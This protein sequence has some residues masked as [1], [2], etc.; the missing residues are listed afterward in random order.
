MVHGLIVA[1]LPRKTARDLGRFIMASAK[2]L[3]VIS[4]NFKRLW[5]DSENDRFRHPEIVVFAL[6]SV[7]Q[8]A[9]NT[10]RSPHPKT[11]ESIFIYSAGDLFAC[12][13]HI[14]AMHIETQ[15]SYLY[16]FYGCLDSATDTDTHGL[17]RQPS[18][19]SPPIT[20]I[21]QKIVKV[22]CA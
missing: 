4:L 3:H 11:P 17:Q 12:F 20:W 14:F 9:K 7:S 22:I 13:L 1:D 15:F 10:T 19:I 2:P 16:L 5:R 21:A 18:I 8:F 6:A